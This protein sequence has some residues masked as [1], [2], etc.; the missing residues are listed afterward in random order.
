[1]FNHPGFDLP[2]RG[3]AGP[4]TA[5]CLVTAWASGSRPIRAGALAPEWGYVAAALV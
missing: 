3:L 5:D 2:T 1:M 4:L